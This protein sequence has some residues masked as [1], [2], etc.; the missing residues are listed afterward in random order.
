M[1]RWLVIS[2]LQIPFE[3]A[4][5]LEFCRDV[6]K[7]LKVPLRS[8]D[9]RDGGVICV[10]DELDNYYG[11]RYPKSPEARHTARSEF[12]ESYEKLREWKAAFPS[13]W[14]CA[15][16][17]GARWDDRQEEAGVPLPYRKHYTQA[18]DYPKTWRL[19]KKWVINSKHRWQAIHGLGYSSMYSYRMIPLHQGISTAFGHLHSSA[20]IA[21][22]N[23]TVD[24]TGA[25]WGLNSGCLVD[26]TAYAF[27]YGEDCQFKPV[28]SIG[29][30]VDD[31]L[32]PL[33]F[34]YPYEK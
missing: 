30:V 27:K 3:A 16:N 28:L 13:M 22:I 5:A 17:H 7:D 12:Q 10:G 14:I 9:L 23:P 32:T 4:K 24:G 19:A 15:S 21:H 8:T 6:A 20:G 33:L 25:R 2:D 34:R 31:G 1:S 26:P 11:S 18:L 29:A